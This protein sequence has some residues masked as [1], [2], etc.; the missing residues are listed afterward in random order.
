MP[1]GVGNAFVADTNHGAASA[2]SWG[3]PWVI[4]HDDKARVFTQ[5]ERVSGVSIRY[6]KVTR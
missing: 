6:E 2:A 4:R 1:S 5:N 3:G